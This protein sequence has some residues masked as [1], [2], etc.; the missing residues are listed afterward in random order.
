MGD[1]VYAIHVAK[2]ELREA[3]NTGDVDRLIA[4]LDDGLIDYS[5]GRRSQFGPE[6]KIVLREHLQELLARYNARLAPIVIEVQVFGD[7]ALEYGWHE[8]TLTPK[9]GGEPIYSRTRYVDL[10]RKNKDGSWKLAL[11]MDNADIPDQMSTAP[12]AG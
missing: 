5:D 6:A 11:F 8:L 3:Y 4:I 1:D 7:I 12:A 2:T 9:G 10:W